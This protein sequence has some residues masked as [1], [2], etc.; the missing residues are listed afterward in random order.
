MGR[1]P[2]PSV[3]AVGVLLF[4]AGC[5]DLDALRARDANVAHWTFDGV[6]GTTVEDVSG[7][8]NAGTLLGGAVIELDR[9]GGGALALDGVQT[10]MRV[11]SS[12]S[13][14]SL[15]EAGTIALWSLVDVLDNRGAVLAG[16]RVGPEAED[17]W[18][19]GYYDTSY[20]AFT[21]TDVVPDGGIL[22]GGVPPI[23]TWVHVALVIDGA[24]VRLYR[25]GVEVGN[26]TIPTPL[27]ESDTPI[28]IG[29]GD[30]GGAGIREYVTG[31][32]DDVRL[33]DHALS[34][35]ELMALAN[36]R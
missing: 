14:N 25:D 2:S 4:A 6:T 34:R 18:T 10:Y 24:T 32:I 19:V 31:R 13:I 29:A 33:Y 5:F 22:A 12:P 17:L 23:A 35:A 28:F 26:E 21:R 20:Y 15:R 30:N 27:P 11:M 16:R 3:P 8:G 36:E 9:H 1:R 7:H